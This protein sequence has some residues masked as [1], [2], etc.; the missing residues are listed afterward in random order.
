MEQEGEGVR[1]GARGR[2][3]RSLRARSLRRGR[4]GDLRGWRHA[5]RGIV[6]V[7]C[8]V[9]ARRCCVVR[10]AAVDLMRGIYTLFP[11]HIF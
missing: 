4:R 2:E 9:E 11:P 8:H 6:Y 3:C 10:G 1:G 7:C 5:L